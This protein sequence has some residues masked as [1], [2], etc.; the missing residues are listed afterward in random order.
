MKASLTDAGCE[1]NCERILQKILFPTDFSPNAE[2][3]LDF[4]SQIVTAA[5]PSV[6]VVHVLEPASR[7]TEASDEAEHASTRLQA[8]EERLRAAGAKSVEVILRQGKPTT[9]LLEVATKDRHS[10]IVMGSQGAGFIRE[11]FLGSLSHNL[12]RYAYQPVLLVPAA[13]D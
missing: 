3:A 6:T 10:L 11:V 7:S 5:Q 4:L 2:L 8:I 1:L 12:V 9:E 13:R